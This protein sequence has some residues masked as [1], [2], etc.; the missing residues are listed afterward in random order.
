MIAGKIILILVFLIV[1][2]MFIFCLLFISK[3]EDDEQSRC[4][5]NSSCVGCPFCGVKNEKN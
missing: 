5:K 2:I 4:D 1:F 3:E